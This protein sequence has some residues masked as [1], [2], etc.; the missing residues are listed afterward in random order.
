MTRVGIV[1]AGNEAERDDVVLRAVNPAA[2]VLLSRERIAHGVDD[3]ACCDASGGDFPQLFH[4]N[5]VDLRIAPLIESKC[6]TSCLVR[7]PRVPSASTM[8][9]ALRSYPGSKLDFFWPLLVHAFV[10]GANADDVIAFDKQ[11]DARETR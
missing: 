11:L 4:A 1:E 6:P 5:A 2:A 10:V 9:L 7:E 3:F 8:T